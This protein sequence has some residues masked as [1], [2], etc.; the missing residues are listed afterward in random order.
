MSHKSHMILN[1][2]CS[3]SCFLDLQKTPTAILQ[4]DTT[5]LFPLLLFMTQRRTGTL[6]WQDGASV[7]FELS[8]MFLSLLRVFFFIWYTFGKRQDNVLL[9]NLPWRQYSCISKWQHYLTAF[10]RSLV[11]PRE[12]LL[13]SPLLPYSSISVNCFTSWVSSLQM[14]TPL[15]LTNKSTWKSAYRIYIIKF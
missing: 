9:W 4:R 7:W 15:Y 5:R 3:V 12:S 11:V 6:K 8:E 13:Q 1:L 2:H 10:T 14:V